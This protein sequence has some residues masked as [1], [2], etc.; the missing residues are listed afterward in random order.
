V[1][2]SRMKIILL[3]VN[4]KLHN[5]SLEHVQSIKNGNL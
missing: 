5:I 3:Y 1:F 2:D 4:L